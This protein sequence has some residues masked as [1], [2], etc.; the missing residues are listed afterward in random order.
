[1]RPSGRNP[2]QMR[3]VSITR[4]YTK[5]A[6]GAPFSRAELDSLLALAELGIGQLIA[7]QKTALGI[8]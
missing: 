4:A 3:D 5:H 2:R 7:K 1:M 6:E 8:A